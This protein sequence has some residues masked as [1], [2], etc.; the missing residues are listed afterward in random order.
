LR[1]TPVTRSS[2]TPTSTRTPIRIR[3]HGR[4]DHGHHDHRL[5]RGRAG[6]SWKHAR[7]LELAVGERNGDPRYYALSLHEADVTDATSR[8]R[9]TGPPIVLEQGKPIEITVANTLKESTA[10]HWHGIELESYYDGVPGWGGIDEKRAP[11]IEP[12][13]KF[14]ARMVPSRAGTFIYHTHW[15]DN[16]QLTGG[17]HGPLIVMPPARRT[18]PTS[19]SR[20]SSAKAQGTRSATRNS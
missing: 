20:T 10:V 7:K 19:T 11:A 5:A 6:R 14:V 4:H 9:L 1:S 18:T 17:V 2:T 16:A 12:G 3:G 15:H 8:G 13:H